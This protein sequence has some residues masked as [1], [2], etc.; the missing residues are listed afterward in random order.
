MTIL[1]LSQISTGSQKLDPPTIPC[2]RKREGGGGG[3]KGGGST[4]GRLAAL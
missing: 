3:G 4:Q 1:N 2:L